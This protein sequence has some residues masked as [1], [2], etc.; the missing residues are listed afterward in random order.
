MKT[1]TDYPNYVFFWKEDEEN[2][3]FCN[4]YRQ[5]FVIDDFRYFC[6]EQYM[7]AEKARLFHDSERYTAILKSN[8]A[9]ECKALGRMVYPYDGAVW[10]ARRYDVVKTANREKYRQNPA[11]M[12]R[13][14]ATGNSILAEASPNDAVWGIALDAESAAEMNPEDWPGQNL[15][16]RILVE[17]REEFRPV[18]RSRQQ[19]V[20]RAVMGDITKIGDVQAIANAAK[21]SLLGGGGVDGAI[22]RAAGPQLLEEC[23]GLNGC[24]TGEAKLTG[25]YRLPCRYVIHTVGPV[26][27]GGWQ[28]EDT[29]LASSY[30]SSLQVALENGIRSVAFPSI[31][32]GI[33]GYPKD[34]AA[35]VAVKAVREFVAEHPDAFDLIEWVLID[36]GT[37]RCYTEALKLLEGIWT[38]Q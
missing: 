7:M 11:L 22:H 10:D 8:S 35:R 9:R 2:G 27:E 16:G 5:S 33:F 24:R 30:K 25:A 19:T 31:S 23:R 37:Y 12:E 4:W 14:L 26:W 1:S 32:T 28:K 36:D 17:L 6:V 13:L 29:K 18:G 34:Q 20:I 15:L 3:C 38:D 21:N